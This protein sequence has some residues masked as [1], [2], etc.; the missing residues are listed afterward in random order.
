MREKKPIGFEPKDEPISRA[1]A[2]EFYALIHDM[3][4]NS[5]TLQNSNDNPLREGDNF[6]NY[7]QVMRL[8]SNAVM[9]YLGETGGFPDYRT[10]QKITAILEDRKLSGGRRL[11]NELVDLIAARKGMDHPDCQAF[12]RANSGNADFMRVIENSAK[13]MARA[14]TGQ[15]LRGLVDS[16]E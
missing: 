5:F 15:L 12:I 7:G 4:E 14:K 1:E 11:I 9:L 16:L 6:R 13:E 10:L 8:I 2:A 3:V